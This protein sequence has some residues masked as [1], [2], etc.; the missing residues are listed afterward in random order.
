MAKGV[1]G[2]FLNLGSFGL[3]PKASLKAGGFFGGA[4][5][6]A[7]S[8]LIPLPQPPSADVAGVKAENIARVKK[9][10]MSKSIYSSPLGV[11]GEASVAR[12]TLLGQ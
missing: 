1:V 9:S 12:K 4:A 7:A 3:I 10:A 8:Q 6:Q 11:S 2:T 5:K